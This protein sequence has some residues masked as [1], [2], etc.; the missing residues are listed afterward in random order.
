MEDLEE[1]KCSQKFIFGPSKIYPS[2]TKLKLP[3]A[4]KEL[5]NDNLIKKNID[6]FVIEADNAINIPLLCG[7]N[8]MQLWETDL[9]LRPTETFF[10]IKGREMEYFETTGKHGSGGGRRGLNNIGTDTGKYIR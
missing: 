10:K 8:T 7:K 6:V 9:S 5:G 4:V 2:Y 3:I 1:R